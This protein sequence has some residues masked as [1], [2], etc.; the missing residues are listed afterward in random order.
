MP[1]IMEGTYYVDDA[2]GDDARSG[3]SPAESW[4]TLQKVNSAELKPGDRVLFRRG[5]QWRGQLFPRSGS[6]SAPVS[7]GAYGKGPKPLL[8]G[9]TSMNSPDDW[10]LESP[11]VWSTKPAE[12][13][14]IGIVADLSAIK[15][16]LYVEG[17]AEASLS[18]PAS[19]DQKAEWTA[20]CR[21]RGAER[22]HV[23]FYTDGVIRI[24][25]GDSL[26]F[27]FSAR[28]DK[29]FAM[30]NIIIMQPRSPWSDY[31]SLSVARPADVGSEW[32]AYTVRFKC[33]RTA[34]D[35][36][37]CIFLG[38]AIP[39][40]STFQF[41]PG[42]LVKE[43]CLRGYLLGADV[44]N[45]I[46]DG[47]ATCG[48]KKWKVEDLQKDGDY[49]FD[50]AM[51]CVK[52]RCESN[53]A[54][55]HKSIELALNKHVIDQSG[56]HHVAY[57]GLDV[58]YGAAHGFGGGDTRNITIRD[59]DLSYIGGGHQFT[60]A[61]GRPVRFGNAIEFWG[62]ARDSIVEGCRIWEVYDAALTNQASGRGTVQTNIIYRNNMIW[63]SEYSFEYWNRPEDSITENIVFE[64]NVCV[65]AGFGW[66]HEQRPDPN[67]RHLMF[68]QNPAQ[69]RGVVVRRNVFCNSRHSG[70]RMENDWLTGL[71][72]DH[73]L[74]FE[75]SGPL[76]LYMG[77]NYAAEDFDAFRKTTGQC[78]NCVFAMPKFVN[79]QERDY[80]LAPDSPRAW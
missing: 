35:G 26:R 64:D 29:P 21:K 25:A 6:D 57:E 62:N 74:W 54:G 39:D 66:G 63:N 28:C 41:R 20:R 47:G 51:R 67:G 9:S 1:E 38:G 53:P 56:R 76:F 7:Y 48:V 17:G 68:Y 32:K 36:R 80:R 34:E 23:Q 77:K 11:G 45:I 4:Q 40:E 5:G 61:D 3:L 60:T 79:A 58:R 15:W 55:A 10:A 59:C 46:F 42:A 19:G 37:L 13:R 50:P 65:D 33:G 52:L 44:G 72:M 18:G 27:D 2:G 49:F 22:H 73:N 24:Q 14:D 8:R 12:Y 70:L 78:A 30:K 16:N 31:A 69:T 43:E 75:E 71:A